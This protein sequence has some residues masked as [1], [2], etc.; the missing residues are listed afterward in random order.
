MIL[1]GTYYW[2]LLLDIMSISI[3]V[4][5]GVVCYCIM[6]IIISSISSSIT[7]RIHVWYIYGNI[8]HPYTPN[9]SIYAIHGSY[10]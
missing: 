2:L 8:Y 7:H 6:S 1:I 4:V 9:V 10:G 5:L 3:I